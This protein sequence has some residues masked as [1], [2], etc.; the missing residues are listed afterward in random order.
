MGG[1][2]QSGR[3]ISSASRAV[4]RRQER[5]IALLVNGRRFFQF[6]FLDMRTGSAVRIGLALTTNHRSLTTA[7]SAFSSYTNR[8]PDFKPAFCANEKR[9]ED[10][11]AA[12]VGRGIVRTW[13]R[14]GPSAG[15]RA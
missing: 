3:I 10:M 15:Q 13:P 12:F 1:A 4:L 2:R 5:R 6:A 11:R 14:T 8:W 9:P 7:V